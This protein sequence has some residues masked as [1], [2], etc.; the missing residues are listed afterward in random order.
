MN[1]H[2][3]T[4]EDKTKRQNIGYQETILARN[5]SLERNVQV[6]K[7]Y[8]ATHCKGTILK[9]SEGDCIEKTW[10]TSYTGRDSAGTT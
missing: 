5:T 4:G 7:I 3:A 6:P 10:V 9:I 1:W 8:G 2:K